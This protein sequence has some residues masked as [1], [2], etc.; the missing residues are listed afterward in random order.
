ML[1]YFEGTRDIFG[2]NLMEQEISLLLKELWQK[3]LGNNEFINREQRRKSGILRDQGST[4]PLPRV[5][6]ISYT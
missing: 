4:L 2:I 5:V 1:L 3:S 6:P